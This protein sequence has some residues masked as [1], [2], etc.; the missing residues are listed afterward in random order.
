MDDS[1]N[2]LTSSRVRARYSDCSDMWLWR[3]LRDDPH[4]PR[5]L[6]IS[7]RRFWRLADLRRWEASQKNQSH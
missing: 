3:R 7:G 4:F 1:E 6:I 2:L 5:P